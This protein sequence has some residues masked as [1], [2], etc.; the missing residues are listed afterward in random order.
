MAHAQSFRYDAGSEPYLYLCAAAADQ[1]RI[2]PLMKRLFRRGVRVWVA[3]EDAQSA[4]EH[5]L[6]KARMS[7]ASLVAVYLTEAFRADVNAKSQ[8]LACQ[9]RG[10]RLLCLNLDGGDSGLSIG[11]RRDTVSLPL[12]NATPEEIEDALL[13]ADGFTQELIGPPGFVE[14]HWVRTLAVVS[15]VLAALVLIGALLYSYLK[16][17]DPS[18]PLPEDTVTFSDSVLQAAVRNAVDGPITEDALNTVTELSFSTLPADLSELAQI[19]NLARIALDQAT[20]LA[21][22]D[23]VMALSDTY[24]IILIGG[25][26]T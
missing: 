2:R 6:Q 18:V 9:S 24:E 17:K 15:A 10:Q 13:H 12:K 11:L 3:D 26:G 20:A 14:T 5:R 4:D 7:N 19:P 1:K 22:K 25:D 21:N 16:P 23:R 8:A